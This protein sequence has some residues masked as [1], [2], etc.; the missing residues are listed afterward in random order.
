MRAR[1]KRETSRA[2]ASD[3]CCAEAAERHQNERNNEKKSGHVL[4]HPVIDLSAF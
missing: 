2:Q 1:Q 4:R 3:P